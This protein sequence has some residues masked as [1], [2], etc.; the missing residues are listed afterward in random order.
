MSHTAEVLEA[1]NTERFAEVFNAPYT[2]PTAEEF[3]DH[4]AAA[5][6]EGTQEIGSL[7][8]GLSALRVVDQPPTAVAI[9]DLD[10]MIGNLGLSLRRLEHPDEP[11]DLLEY[12]TH[13][14]G[15]GLTLFTDDD[16]DRKYPL[17]RH[18]KRQGML[19]VREIAAIRDIISGWREAGVYVSFITSAIE[20]AELDHI[21]FVAQHLLGQ[22]DGMII[23][24]GHYKLV[25]K[26]K[27]AVELMDFLGAAEGT[28]VVHLDDLPHNT[29]K[30]RAALQSDPRNFAVHSIQHYFPG[31]H[32]GADNGAWWGLTPL[33]CFELASRR[34]E[35][36]V[37]AVLP[38]STY[39]GR[40]ATEQAVTA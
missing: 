26:G 18:V 37:E 3:R 14:Y 32:Q 9:L 19:P 30:V 28:P 22:C 21:N 39:A 8:D 25:D 38:V 29:Q 13:D 27:A 20:G 6:W 11:E 7:E 4:F 23:T 16:L 35:A 12:F 2:Q 24:S 15:Q 1:D 40:S 10:D 5:V 31:I 36:G 34:L 33:R 17:I